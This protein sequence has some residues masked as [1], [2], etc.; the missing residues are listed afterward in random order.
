MTKE[1]PPVPPEELFDPFRHGI[2]K[3]EGT[4]RWRA[5]PPPKDT[6]KDEEKD[7]K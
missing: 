7:A 3:K 4:D 2:K 1:K 6:P 5:V